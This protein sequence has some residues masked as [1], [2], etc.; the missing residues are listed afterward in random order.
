MTHSTQSYKLRLPCFKIIVLVSCLYRC[1]HAA[2]CAHWRDVLHR[3]AIQAPNATVA[4]C[5]GFTAGK[6]RFQTN[7]ALVVW[8][9]SVEFFNRG[10]LANFVHSVYTAVI[11]S[12]S[13]P[14]VGALSPFFCLLFD[15]QIKGC[16]TIHVVWLF[17]VSSLDVL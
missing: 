10:R 15:F 2:C 17:V 13:T 3:K 11:N 4:A 16:S 6:Q 12:D 9:C 7:M 8:D 1:F 5:N 14:L